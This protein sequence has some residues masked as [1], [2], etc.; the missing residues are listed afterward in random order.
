MYPKSMMSLGLLPLCPIVN[1]QD[2]E[3]EGWA[4]EVLIL[5]TLKLSPGGIAP[6][7]GLQPVLPWTSSKRFMEFC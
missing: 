4:F 7:T 3:Q 1:L 2:L 5:K 6:I